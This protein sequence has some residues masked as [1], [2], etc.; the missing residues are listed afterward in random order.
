MTDDVKCL[1]PRNKNCVFLEDGNCNLQHKEEKKTMKLV[2]R[3]CKNCEYTPNP[4]SS[5]CQVCKENIRYI[6]I[7]DS[8]LVGVK[9]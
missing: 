7:N 4:Y 5:V 8:K 1:C 2:R 6:E 3:T 9:E